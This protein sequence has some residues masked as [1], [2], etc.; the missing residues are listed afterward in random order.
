[1]R[2]YADA[3]ETV[4]PPCTVA[5]VQL[6]PFC[7]GHH[8][9]FKRLN[10]P[11]A[12]NPQADCGPDNI[13]LGIAIC[14]LSYHAALDAIHCGTLAGIIERWQKRIAGR[15]WRP[16]RLD[17]ESM[18]ATFRAYLTDGYQMPPIMRHTST[19]IELTSPWETLLKVRL[20]MAGFDECEIL[21]GYLPG[22]WYDYF[23]ALE[24]SAASECI[25]PKNWR[26]VFFTKDLA[27]KME[28]ADG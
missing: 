20:S 11:F 3:R 4:P 12:G 8:L 6:R 10:L 1:M 9:L 19:G 14:G 27:E 7:L 24:L 2:R 21:N 5:G 15:W 23:T 16:I 18:E 17:A 22:R 28:A 13:V 25:D 26:R